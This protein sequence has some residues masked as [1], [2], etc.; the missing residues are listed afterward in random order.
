MIV[1]LIILLLIGGPEG[2]IM[3]LSGDEFLL[4]WNPIGWILEDLE[5]SEAPPK[6]CLPVEPLVMD[7]TQSTVTAVDFCNDEQLVALTHLG[8][9]LSEKAI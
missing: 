6:C 8:R 5:C 7:S 4:K 9:F 3:T 2:F 1:L